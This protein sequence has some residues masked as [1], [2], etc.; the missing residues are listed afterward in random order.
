MTVLDVGGGVGTSLRDVRVVGNSGTGTSTWHTLWILGT[1]EVACHGYSSNGQ[2]GAGAVGPTY[3]SP[4]KVLAVGGGSPLTNIL[5][6]SAGYYTSCAVL[7]DGR[8]VCMGRDGNGQ[9]VGTTA[10]MQ[11]MWRT[12]SR[13]LLALALT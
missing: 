2:C 1:R 9:L 10:P 11:H 3:S 4:V 13:Q 12:F 5:V 7:L 6:V 8:T